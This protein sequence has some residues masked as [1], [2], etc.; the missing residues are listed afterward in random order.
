MGDGWH[1]SCCWWIGCAVS[2]RVAGVIGCV[3][4]LAVQTILFC[5]KRKLKQLVPCVR[6]GWPRKPGVLGGVGHQQGMVAGI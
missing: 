5:G 1:E 3:V 2:N 4:V 6:K